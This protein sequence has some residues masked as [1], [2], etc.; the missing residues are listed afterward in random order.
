MATASTQRSLF[1]GLKKSP[2]ILVSGGHLTPALA[3]M[4]YF[5]RHHADVKILFVG[6]EFSQEREKQ[7]AKEREA[8]D[9]MGIPFFSIRAAKFH[10]VAWYRNFFELPRLIPSL[11]QAWVLLRENEVDLFLSFGGYLAVPIAFAAKM[12]GRKVVTHEQT[13]T[14]GLANDL[15]ALMADRV[16]I[17][18]DESR[19]QF[20]KHKTVLTGN[21]LRASLLKPV[22]KAPE[23]MPATKKPILYITGGSQGSQVINQSVRQILPLLTEKFFVVHQCGQS[24]HQ[25][26]LAE[27]QDAADK[28]PEELSSSYVVRE[29]MLEKE[30]SWLFQNAVLAIARSGA[31][32]TLEIALHAVPTIFIP[33]PFSHNNEQLKNAQALVDA[34]AALLLEQKELDSRSLW[35]AVREGSAQ[36]A[37]MR[38][39]AE[40]RRSELKTDGAQALAE[41]CLSLLRFEGWIPPVQHWLAVAKRN[42]VRLKSRGSSSSSLS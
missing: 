23:W 42:L 33:L 17:S 39:R 3:T 32:T 8:C 15:I 16:A 28:L 37:Y 13:K 22:S 20:P 10:R 41:L 18:F 4:E 19:K 12:L 34:G 11:Y 2:V 40:K 30:V 31:N 25:R 29:W 24:E 6:R 7:V 1:G 21:P 36:R 27:L 38:K 35:Q 14:S 26:Y 5:Q 9:A